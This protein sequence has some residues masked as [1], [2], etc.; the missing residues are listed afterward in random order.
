M[1]RDYGAPAART[2]QWADVD[3]TVYGDDDPM[4]GEPRTELGHAR[5]LIYVYGDRMR[6][7]SAWRR[8]LVWDGIRWS[9]DGTG[10]AARWAKAAWW[11]PVMNR[12]RHWSRW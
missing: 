5:R 12:T 9:L 3:G 4:P 10:Q 6:Y 11:R 8:W 1:I 2:D 7:V